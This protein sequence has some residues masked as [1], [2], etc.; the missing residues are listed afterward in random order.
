MDNFVELSDEEI[1]KIGG[2]YAVSEPLIDRR[3]I[4]I[5][6][7]IKVKKRFPWIFR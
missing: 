7:P 2:G 1:S 6:P 5:D 4:D 3:V